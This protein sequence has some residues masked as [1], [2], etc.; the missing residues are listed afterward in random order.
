MR[1]I[2]KGSQAA[3]G[4][5]RSETEGERSLTATILTAALHA[6]MLAN[7]RA[8]A[9][10][11]TNPT[12]L[13]DANRRTSCDK[14]IRTAPPLLWEEEEPTETDRDLE[15]PTRH[16]QRPNPPERTCRHPQSPTRHIQG[17]TDTY[18]YLQATY[19]DLIHPT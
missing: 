11:T 6:P 16:L 5:C 15:T 8:A 9:L 18:K 4:L 19:T 2:D 14:N 1:E 17:P 3:A 12:A 7:S 13:V 10:F